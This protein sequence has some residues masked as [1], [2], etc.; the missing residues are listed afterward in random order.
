ML[1]NL[2]ADFEIYAVSSIDDKVPPNF[3]GRPYGDCAVFAKRSMCSILN[4][5]SSIHFRAQALLLT[6]STVDIL[7]FNVYFPC[8]C[9]SVDNNV[10]L[11]IICSFLRECI[12][13][14]YC[15]NLRVVICDDFNANWDIINLLNLNANYHIIVHVVINKLPKCF[16]LNLLF[17]YNYLVKRI[18]FLL[19][20]IIFVWYGF[21]FLLL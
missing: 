5:G 20:L 9:S 18:K 11:N 12:D 10:D 14:R 2:T 13:S 1:N 16:I 3:S 19:F 21:S 15:N 6:F 17:N 8:L 7:L 4:L